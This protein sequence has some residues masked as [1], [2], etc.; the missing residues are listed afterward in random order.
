MLPTRQTLMTRTKIALIILV[1]LYV[2]GFLF[3]DKPIAQWMHLYA[4]GTIWAQLANIL[5][6]YTKS[7]LV[8][9][10]GILCLL[11]GWQRFGKNANWT[12]AYGWW[13]FG[14]TTTC[15][16]LICYVI[17]MIVG[18]YRPVEWLNHGLYGFHWLSI[19]YNFTSTPSG[20]AT[21]AFA[22]AVSLFYIVNCKWFRT[23]IIL[24]AFCIAIS[25]VIVTAHYL[26]DIILGGFIGTIVAWWVHYYLSLKLRPK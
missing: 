5:S 7:F 24:L 25:R 13:L 12:Q 17:K 15:A 4:T 11:V 10:L 23:L 18:R 16:I 26:S 19:Q 22:A 6:R 3:L 2:I 8:L 21:A 20:H 14:G 1:V 9:A